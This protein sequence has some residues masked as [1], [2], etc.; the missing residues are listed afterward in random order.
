MISTRENCKKPKTIVNN[1]SNL[2]ERNNTLF[3]LKKI[4]DHF[5]RNRIV[6][7]SWGKGTYLK[8]ITRTSTWGSLQRK[9]YRAW[10]LLKLDPLVSIPYLLRYLY[11]LDFVILLKPLNIDPTYSFHRS[12]EKRLSLWR[13]CSSLQ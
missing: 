9:N 5:K 10:R 2:E 6:I 13:F 7:I 1:H 4:C 8:K 12:H 3:C 11:K